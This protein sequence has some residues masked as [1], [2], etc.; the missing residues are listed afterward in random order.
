MIVY[1]QDI[2]LRGPRVR[3]AVDWWAKLNAEVRTVLAEEYF[4]LMQTRDWFEDGDLGTYS[5]PDELLCLAKFHE[6]CMI[7]KIRPSSN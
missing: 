7:R 4:T 3:Q 1:E 5:H 6:H 2:Q